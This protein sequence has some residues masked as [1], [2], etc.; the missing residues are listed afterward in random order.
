MS[1]APLGMKI[2]EEQKRAFV[3]I[4]KIQSLQ[5]MQILTYQYAPPLIP[6]RWHFHAYHLF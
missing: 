3:I 6:L 1:R 4:K 5:K 2:P